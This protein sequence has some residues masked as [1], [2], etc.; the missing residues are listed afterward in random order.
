MTADDFARLALALPDAV[1][2]AHFGKRDF[3]IGNKIFASLPS[4]DLA[5]LKLVPDQQAMVVE[6]HGPLF[7]A[8]ANAWGVRGWTHL[9]LADCAEDIAKAALVL[10]WTNAA[11]KSLRKSLAQPPISGVRSSSSA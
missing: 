10:A 5:A 9:A 1:E 11:P 8:V 3:R 7:S 4:P 2:S 6:M